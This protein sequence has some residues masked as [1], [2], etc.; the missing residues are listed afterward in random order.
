MRHLIL[1]IIAASLFFL[2]APSAQGEVFFF[3][4]KNNDFYF[5]DNPPN[6]SFK[7][8]FPA[9]HKKI[10]K[11]YRSGRDVRSNKAVKKQIQKVSKEYKVDSKLIEAIIQVESGFDP[12]AISRAGAMGLM[13]LMPETAKDMGVRYPYDPLQNITGG[14]KYFRKMLKTFRGNTK[15]ALAA[16]NAGPTAVKAYRGVP[17][18][19]ETRNYVKKVLAAYNKKNPRKKIQPQREKI[20]HIVQK[21]GTLLLR[22]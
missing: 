5:T 10:R 8:L 21:D 1:S 7:R 19:T 22:N 6:S 16:Y 13:Q 3:R 17:P 4:D 14:T 11:A 18:Y 2:Q 12:K 9:K 20:F 15:L